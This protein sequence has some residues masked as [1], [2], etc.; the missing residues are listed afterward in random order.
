MPD[1]NWK[2][3]VSPIPQ[4]V[5]GAQTQAEGPGGEPSIK[6]EFGRMFS[7][8]G[9]GVGGANLQVIPPAAQNYTVISGL[10]REELENLQELQNGYKSQLSHATKRRKLQDEEKPD[11]ESSTGQN[12]PSGRA[13]RRKAGHHHQ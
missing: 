4:A 1:T 12:T 13:K 3:R 10:R 7:G 6:N 5:L 8:I 11:E 2:E 9:S